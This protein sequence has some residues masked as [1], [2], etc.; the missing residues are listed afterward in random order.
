MS[1]QDFDFTA[2]DKAIERLMGMKPESI[3][4]LSETAA[5]KLYNA[6]L[7]EGT[8]EQAEAYMNIKRRGKTA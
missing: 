7:A 2:R 5:R 8:E 1:K 6:I 3:E 4:K